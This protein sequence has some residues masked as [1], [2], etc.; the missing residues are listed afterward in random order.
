M[1]LSRIRD[2]WASRRRRPPL[3]PGVVV[4]RRAAAVRER[5]RL[6]DLSRR[7]R[8]VRADLSHAAGQQFLPGKWTRIRAGRLAYVDLL[9][10]TCA[11]VGVTNE[12]RELRGFDRH[13]EVLRVEAAL[14]TKGVELQALGAE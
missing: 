6:D 5:Q 14:A 2:R 3:G 4:L 1:T 11:L 9:V 7:L 12:L 10:E 8:R 13:L